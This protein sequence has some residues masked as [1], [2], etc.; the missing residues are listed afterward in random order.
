MDRNKNTW[1]IIKND[2]NSKPLGIAFICF[3]DTGND[4]PF[5]YNAIKLFSKCI[6]E[7]QINIEKKQEKHKNERINLAEIK[8]MIWNARSLSS[9]TK[10][11][12]LI[13]IVR[14]ESPY[15]VI[16]SET[17][18][19]DSDSPFVKGYRTY[20]T[21]N[22]IRR[23]GTCILVSKNILASIIVLKNNIN[24]RYIQISLKAPDN[25]IPTT[26]AFIYLEPNGNMNEIPNEIMESNII[27]GDL[28]NNE[29]GL[30]KIGVY[31]MKGIFDVSKISIN[32]K[33]SDHDIIIGKSKGEFKLNERFT[34][35]I[36]NNKKI[37]GKK[38]F[39]Y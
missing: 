33:I 2:Q 7:S 34:K 8:V 12:F 18:L 5:H 23:K 32:K 38:Y 20:K 22:N 17:F 13:D 14:N 4:L 10:K 19:L 36:I 29:S 28:N 21:K 39:I 24:G 6:P 35:I 31:H 15:I 27:G 37:Y 3:H 11:C 26:I 1:R 30:L 16:I 25:Q 9:S